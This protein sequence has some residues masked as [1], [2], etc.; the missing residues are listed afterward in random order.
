MT[1]VIIYGVGIFYNF[2]V[3]LPPNPNLSRAS[4][5]LMAIK[6][7][8]KYPPKTVGVVNSSN[9]VRNAKCLPRAFYNASISIGGIL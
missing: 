7:R 3:C 5:P 9:T 1:S 6:D 4:S 2:A 8:V